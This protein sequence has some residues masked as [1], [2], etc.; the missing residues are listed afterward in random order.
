[1]FALRQS[2]GT[3]LVRNWCK[4]ERE[5]AKGYGLEDIVSNYKIPGRRRTKRSRMG[6]HAI[7]LKFIK[8]F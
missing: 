4:A 8:R 3:V 7:V 6:R 2:R 5:A 1:M